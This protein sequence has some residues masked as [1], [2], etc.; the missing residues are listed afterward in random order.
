MNTFILFQNPTG[1]ECWA[2]REGIY[3]IEM[4]GTSYTA[5]W[6]QRLAYNGGGNVDRWPTWRIIPGLLS[7]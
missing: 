1:N 6:T 7:G 2:L 5:L 4:V 3:K